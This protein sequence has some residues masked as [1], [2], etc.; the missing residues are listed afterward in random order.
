M[1]AKQ[2]AQWWMGIHPN[3]IKDDLPGVFTDRD[4]A[5]AAC[6]EIIKIFEDQMP[7]LTS[8]YWKEVKRQL[9]SYDYLKK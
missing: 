6:D 5:M 2:R 8:N 9:E 7:P 3:Q 1:T 4:N